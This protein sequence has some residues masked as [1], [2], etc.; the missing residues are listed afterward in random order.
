[1]P[2][3]RDVNGDAAPVRDFWLRGIHWGT[4]Y[5]SMDDIAGNALEFIDDDEPTSAREQFLSWENFDKDSIRV[6][7]RPGWCRKATWYQ[8]FIPVEAKTDEDE[9]LEVVNPLHE[10]MLFDISPSTGR[11]IVQPGYR[12]RLI[13]RLSDINLIVANLHH[14]PYFQRDMMLPYFYNEGDL[15]NSFETKRK[16]EEEVG[17]VRIAILHGMGFINWFLKGFPQCL[18]NQVHSADTIARINALHLND[19]ELRGT[20]ID[21]V[22]QKDIVN[23]PLLLR[24]RIPIYYPLTIAVLTDSCFRGLVPDLYAEYEDACAEHSVT[25]IGLSRLGSFN[26]RWAVV[27]Q[28]DIWFQSLAETEVTPSRYFPS[29]IHAYIVDHVN[30]GRRSVEFNQAIAFKGHYNYSEAT[31]ESSEGHYTDV[32]TWKRHEK[33]QRESSGDRHWRYGPE[34]NP[35]EIRERWRDY[36]APNP[37]ETYDSDG[38][39]MSISYARQ[40]FENIYA[41]QGR[42]VRGRRFRD[43]SLEPSS[44]AP[45]YSSPTSSRSRTRTPVRERTRSPSPR[46]NDMEVD[47]PGETGPSLLERLSPTGTV[48]LL[49]VQGQL[50]L[51][52]RL[53]N[54]GRISDEVSAG[55]RSKR[56]STMASDDEEEPRRRHF[57]TEGISTITENSHRPYNGVIPSYRMEDPGIFIIREVLEQQ[58]AP[59]VDWLVAVALWQSKMVPEKVIFDLGSDNTGWNHKIIEHGIL[60]CNENVESQICSLLAVPPSETFGSSSFDVVDALLRRCLP[61][62]L[63]YKRS[64]LDEFK[65]RENLDPFTR[66]LKLSAK[67]ESGEETHVASGAKGDDY[68]IQWMKGAMTMLARPQA[69]GF[70]MQGGSSAYIA[71]NLDKTIYSRFRKG[72]SF[73]VV[74]ATKAL[75]FQ[76]PGTSTTVYCDDVSESEIQVLHGYSP[77][78]QGESQDRWLLPPPELLDHHKQLVT[79][80]GW[81]AA[82]T[83]IFKELLGSLKGDLSYP[84]ATARTKKE[85]RMYIRER[86]YEKRSILSL[87]HIAQEDDWEYGRLLLRSGYSKA[88]NGRILG[89]VDLGTEEFEGDGD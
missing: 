14:N 64:H 11:Y 18:N 69:T 21:F 76:I 4:I 70:L 46:E 65:S 32:V 43:E 55:R 62:R 53:N 48:P 23:L 24:N 26:D 8:A 33:I 88:I 31:V 27:D 1:M 72:P 34:S 61:F 38:I 50:S 86:L 41:E 79:K 5:G 47:L 20:M 15:P 3:F 2:L 68:R 17:A 29:N 52:E 25:E 39:K 74:E 71:G 35:S 9:D 45:A 89:D 84:T 16:L 87:N 77:G 59:T 66:S 51:L 28:F 12:K 60:C 81:N 42:E 13:N 36:C 22:T 83:L 7:M 6:G 67:D 58:R 19:F 80:N 63:A 78:K 56:S 75:S 54:E 57:R 49:S 10:S 82:Y 40:G 30:W 44:P 37:G 85:W 73:M